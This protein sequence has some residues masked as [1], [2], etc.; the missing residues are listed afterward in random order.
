[1][2]VEGLDRGHWRR[3]QARLTGRENMVH[4]A[5]YSVPKG[6]DLTLLRAWSSMSQTI[7]KNTKNTVWMLKT[8]IFRKM[9][10]IKIGFKLQLLKKVLDGSA[11]FC[12][13]KLKNHGF[14]T[15][16]INTI[17]SKF[18]KVSKQSLL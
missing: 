13:E 15:K 9:C 11:W 3:R 4:V 6:D 8:I 7:S 12:L 16:Q 2:L 17:P 14:E 10:Y 18:Q 1:M 5:L